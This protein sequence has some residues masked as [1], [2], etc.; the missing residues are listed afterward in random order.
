E[1]YGFSPEDGHWTFLRAGG[2][3][4]RYTRI[5]FG[6]K[7]FDNLGEELTARTEQDL[8]ALLRA[9]KEGGKKLGAEAVRQRTS[10]RDGA[11]RALELTQLWNDCNLEVAVVLN[12][13]KKRKY[14]G[15]DIWDVMLCL[16]LRWGDMDLF[17]WQNEPGNVGDDALFSVWTS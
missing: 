8:A 11:K 10:P 12:A 15:K 17:H 2:V 1:I 9:I 7:L 16:G 13:D 14:S 6:A 5:C 3:P 4:E